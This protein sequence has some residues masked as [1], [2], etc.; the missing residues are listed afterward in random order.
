MLVIV[1]IVVYNKV[2]RVVALVY[3][4]GEIAKDLGCIYQFYDGSTVVL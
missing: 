2:T 3:L 4:V 1:L